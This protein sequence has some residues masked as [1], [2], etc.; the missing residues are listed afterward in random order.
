MS[1]KIT[2]GCKL[3]LDLTTNKKS[4]TKIPKNWFELTSSIPLDKNHNCICIP[5]GKIN[6]L[7]V[8]DVDNKDDTIEQWDTWIEKNGKIDTYTTKTL[9]KGYHYYFQYD[10]DLKET[11]RC[12]TGMNI[13]LK[14]D[15]GFVVGETSFDNQY[16]AF[17]S[18][19]KIIKMP[20][21]IKNLLI[22]SAFKSFEQSKSN[23]KFYREIVESIPIFRGRG[24]KIEISGDLDL[25]MIFDGRL[26]KTKNNG[27]YFMLRKILMENFKSQLKL[28]EKRTQ[29]QKMYFEYFCEKDLCIL[30]SI[31]VDVG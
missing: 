17:N 18:I 25:V 24:K 13:D 30:L 27:E 12:I 19:D 11:Q 21:W 15:R 16:V 26:I 4:F 6:N 31:F 20:E 3:T 14:S 10:A 1:D 23:Q 29:E 28:L 2:F 9:H 5:T 8:L 22:K 7:I